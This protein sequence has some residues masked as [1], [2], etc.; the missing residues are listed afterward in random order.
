MYGMFTFA[1]NMLA[2]KSFLK[3][4]QG[5]GLINKI[6]IEILYSNIAKF[7]NLSKRCAKGNQVPYI[8]TQ[9]I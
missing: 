3:A 7:A 5:G 6:N 8:S 4:R 1:I 2:E 9:N